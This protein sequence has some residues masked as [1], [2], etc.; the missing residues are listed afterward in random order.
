[1]TLRT[2]MGAVAR[3]CSAVA[4]ALILAAAAD[5]RELMLLVHG[6][7]GSSSDWERSGI[8]ARL[9]EAGWHDGG[10]LAGEPAQPIDAH[11][12]FYVIDLPSLAPLQV[13]AGA[14]ADRI[15]RLRELHPDDYLIVVGHSAGGVV[16]RLV[17]VQQPQVRVDVLIT[18]AAPH[19]GAPLAS[20]GAEL[21]RG[22]VAALPYVAQSPTV[23][24]LQRLYQEL[25]ES[26]PGSLLHWLNHQPHPDAL[27]VSVVRPQD[28]ARMS[29]DPLVPSWSQSLNAVP[30]LV[31]K[32]RD[33]QVPGWHGLGPSDAD[34]LLEFLSQTGV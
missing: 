2:A 23:S 1:M 24:E 4:L 33:V 10:V 28:P 8:T 5:G 13:Q 26:A 30:A 21:G 25:G 32:A 29:F 19:L 20:A 6:H 14:L 17:M 3:G 27:Y 7:F 11:R 9:T 34:W 16:A 15:H 18:I 12:L 31:G 22:L